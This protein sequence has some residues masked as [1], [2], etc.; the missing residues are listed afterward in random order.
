MHQ[1]HSDDRKARGLGEVERRVLTVLA[2]IERPTVTAQD[3]FDRLGLSRQAANLALSRLAQKGWLR[4][5]RRGVYAVVPLSS[6]SAQPV[7]GDP[8][9]V[10]M[11][12]FKPCYISGWTAAQHWDLTEQIFNVVSV[13]SSKPERRSLINVGG[14]RYRIRRVP[15]DAIFG[16]TKVWS[17]RVT[18]QMATVHRTVIDVLDAPEM[19]GGGRQTVDIVRAY[20]ERPDASPGTLYDLA[21]RLGRGSVFKRMGFLAETF[22]SV[23]GEWMER[24]LGKL[25]AGVT[26]L[27]P[28]SPDRG[29]IVSRWKLRVNVPMEDAL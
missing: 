10:A 1:K 7:V 2:A 17:G 20:W 12:L 22:G 3:L 24:F 9:A 26:L 13:Y 11:E 19:G 15:Q 14:V 16:T 5:L 21:A 6:S 23:T 18:I 29:P 27:D 8:L 25:T 28:A 4:R